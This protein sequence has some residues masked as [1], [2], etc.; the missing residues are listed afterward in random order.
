MVMGGGRKTGREKMKKVLTADIERVRMLTEDLCGGLMWGFSQ[1]NLCLGK[2]N[3][4]HYM[5][6]S[7]TYDMKAAE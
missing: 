6:C 4:H 5:S 1:T 3:C 7:V 2:S